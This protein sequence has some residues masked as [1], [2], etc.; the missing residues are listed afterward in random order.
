[1][2]DDGFNGETP[3]TPVIEEQSTDDEG[4][5]TDDW[6]K[7]LKPTTKG[8]FDSPKISPASV[9]Y[10]ED[11]EEEKGGLDGF[12]LGFCRGRN[13]EEQLGSGLVGIIR[14]RETHSWNKRYVPALEEAEEARF[15]AR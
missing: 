4:S 12:G 2:I 11:E 7:E 9:E 14:D 5:E 10:I 8:F 13:S 15:W 6:I 1:M 3:K